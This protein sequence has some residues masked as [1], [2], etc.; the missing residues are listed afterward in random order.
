M[1]LLFGSLV[2]FVGNV[3]GF[4]GSGDVVV[5]VVVDVWGGICGW[6]LCWVLIWCCDVDY[7]SV[8]GL[9]G[10]L[11]G[12]WLSDDVFGCLFVLGWFWCLLL[13]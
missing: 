2:G 7:G 8:W 13:C 4:A 12:G 6:L 3:V 1:L 9:L 10:R 5:Y 11:I